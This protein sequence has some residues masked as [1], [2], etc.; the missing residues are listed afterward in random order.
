LF[1][2][3]TGKVESYWKMYWNALE[4][5]PSSLSNILKVTEEFGRFREF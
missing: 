1:K 4:K 5:V 3:C 2:A